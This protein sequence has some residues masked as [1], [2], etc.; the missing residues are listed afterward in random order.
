M[1]DVNYGCPL[2]PYGIFFYKFHYSM[3]VYDDKKKNAQIIET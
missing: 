2:L 1:L 3:H